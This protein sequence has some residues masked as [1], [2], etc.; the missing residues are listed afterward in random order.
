MFLIGMRSKTSDIAEDE[1]I[2]D[3]RRSFIVWDRERS[4]S[5]SDQLLIAGAQFKH[6]RNSDLHCRVL[7]RMWYCPGASMAAVL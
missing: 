5:N 2:Y 4:R 3:H 1:A 6:K 7:V